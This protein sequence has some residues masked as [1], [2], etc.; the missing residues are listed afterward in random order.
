M[1][2]N[3]IAH[4]SVYCE[5]VAAMDE[6]LLD[7]VEII[8]DNEKD[9]KRLL[10]GI[11]KLLQDNGNESTL[12]GAQLIKILSS[13]NSDSVEK[14][15][16][17]SRLVDGKM[18][19]NQLLVIANDILYGEREKCLGKLFDATQKLLESNE[20]QRMRGA[21]FLIAK[22]QLLCE[23][24]EG[25]GQFLL[26]VFQCSGEQLSA[27]VKIV[28][29]VEE[30]ETE[31]VVSSLSTHLPL[32]GLSSDLG[33]HWLRFIR[34]LCLRL[35]QEKRIPVLRQIILYFHD[36]LSVPQLCRLDLLHQFLL[37]T[38]NNQLFNYEG[39]DYLVLKNGNFFIGANAHTLLTAMVAVPWKDIPL[40]IWLRRLTVTQ[41]PIASLE[42]I[43]KLGSRVQV[44]NN[45]HIRQHVILTFFFLFRITIESL[46]VSDYIHLIAA[47]INKYDEMFYLSD[48]KAKI[49]ASSNFEVHIDSFN[50][51][52]YEL[53]V[54]N[55]EEISGLFPIFIKKL[56]TIPKHKH[57]WWRLILFQ[58]EVNDEVM[59]FYRT[60][61]NV[62]TSMLLKDKSL[63]KIQLH[64]IDR[65]GCKTSEERAFLRS[66]C[67]DLFVLINLKSW[68][69]FN[70]LNLKPLDVLNQVVLNRN[71]FG[72]LVKILGDHSEKLVDE[73]IL[74]DLI[75]HIKTYDEVNAIFKYAEAHLTLE[76][77]EKCVT[78]LLH[79]DSPVWFVANYFDTLTLPIPFLKKMILHGEPLTGDARIEAAYAT[80][81][82][83]EQNRKNFFINCASI[84]EKDDVSKLCDDLL[85]INNELSVEN[86]GY[87]ENS[88][89]HRR[90]I[91]ILIALWRLHK[92]WKWSD[93]LWEA[94]LCS[95][96]LLGI[97]IVY[98]HLV[99]QMLPSIQPLLQKLQVLLTLEATQQ[100]SLLSVIFT[101]LLP[102][103]MVSNSQT[104]RLAQLVLHKLAC[105]S[106]KE[107][108][109][110][111]LANTLKTSLEATLGKELRNHKDDPLFPPIHLMSFSL[112][113]EH[114]L[115]MTNAPFDEYERA[116]DMEYDRTLKKYREG[117][118]LSS[119]ELF[120]SK[121]HEIKST[122]K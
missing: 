120:R 99:A 34:I 40:L 108:T 53:L 26:D 49:E 33:G 85:S 64:L 23:A 45:Y 82:F 97:N 25:I 65:L 30:Q 36:H 79:L 98:E 52:S 21:Y 95:N 18:L 112:K 54:N 93:K 29:S 15:R 118:V 104:R 27:F 41:F 42:L 5:Q 88:K 121:N 39:Q 61:Y 117:A 113:V 57:G 48:V 46:S 6:F 84:S 90:K 55:I 69:Q 50:K 72:H 83:F 107:R 7:L 4:G 114:L 59:D 116:R 110:L 73:S 111:P 20:P 89:V 31:L 115:N 44:F 35:L 28:A 66:R 47:T 94:L 86:P 37:A 10:L 80:K 75:S 76:E 17:Q 102:L 87:L 22:M 51:H 71:T 62:D 58:R 101:L 19:V 24:S 70:D 119:A 1:S 3:G 13:S 122:Q 63:E 8:E 32:L 81:V 38:N 11:P 74:R 14:I 92:Q 12:L 91:R 77:R 105:K 60:V 100:E 56:E 96:D 109:E 68:S 78:D 16:P 67:M 2:R 43:Q 9:L 106:Q 103:T